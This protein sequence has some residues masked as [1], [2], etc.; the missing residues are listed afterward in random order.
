MDISKET[1]ERNFDNWV[2]VAVISGHEPKDMSQDSCD[3][4]SDVHE[5]YFS[6]IRAQA[7]RI[8][9]LEAQN[10]A[11]K[12]ERADIIATKREQLARLEAQ[13][14]T[15]RGDALEE[16]ADWHM[17]VAKHDQSGMDYSEAVGIP[18]NNW[19]DLDLSVKTHEW[20]AREILALLTKEPKT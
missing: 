17:E 2:N 6:T 5:V 20:C 3:F 18:I 8:A 9:E 12:D 16:A 1:V 4:A 19:V 7:A 15:A 14:A 11:L 10:T 13:L